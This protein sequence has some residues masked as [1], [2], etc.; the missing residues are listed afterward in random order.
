MSEEISN[1]KKQLSTLVEKAASS[2]AVSQYAAEN[3]QKLTNASIILKKGIDDLGITRISPKTIEQYLLLHPVIPRGIGIR[4]NFMT[5]RG[6]NIS[7][8]DSSEEAKE[9][10]KRMRELI[11]TSGGDITINNWIQDAYGFGNGYLTLLEAKSGEQ[12]GQIV[13]LSREHP[14]YFRIAREKREGTANELRNLTT[15]ADFTYEWGPMKIDDVTKK[16]LGYTQVVPSK[17]SQDKVVPDGNEISPDRVGHLVFDTWGDEA[18]GISLVQYVHLNLRYLMNIE[19]AGAEAI[20]RSGFTQKV[21]ETEI[22]NENDLEELGTNLADINAADTIILPKGTTMENLQPNDSQF[23]EVHDKFLTLLAIRLGVPKPLLTLDGTNTN[24][25][26]I[27]E[28]RKALMDDLRSDEI[29]VEYTIREQIFRPACKSIFGE[30]FDKFPYFNFNQATESVEERAG[31]IS[32]ISESVKRFTE[33]YVLLA[34]GGQQKA[35]NKLLKFIIDTLPENDV[36]DEEQTAASEDIIVDDPIKP[37]P[38]SENVDESP[39]APVPNP[40]SE[41]NRIRA[42]DE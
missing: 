23:P 12:E 16:P 5:S 39:G 2:E 6:H 42:E 35:A 32:Q 3:A 41:V 40:D 37:E 21:V 31:A 28:Q 33:S 9:A 27:R 11:N 24:K 22:I 25:A 13:H 26:T 10:A 1:Y 18:E 20:Y 19:E 38:G 14:L 34:N 15:Y 30:E 4:A 8:F 17:Q 29:K 36:I 7:P